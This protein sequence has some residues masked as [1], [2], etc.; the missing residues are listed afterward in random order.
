MLAYSGVAHS[1]YMLI[2]ISLLPT[3]TGRN[4]PEVIQG[5]EAVLFYLVAYGA[6][7]IGAFAVIA[8]L[9]TAERSIDNIED[10]AGLHESHPGI[11]L[12]M[13]IFLFS[14]IGL[15]A[16]A[17]FLA[18]FRLF[19]GALG[20]PITSSQ[21]LYQTLAIV[22]A[23]NA[24]I[25]A[26]YYLRVLSVMYLRGSFNAPKPVISYSIL[27]AILFCAAVTIVFGVFPSPLWNA[28]REAFH[29]V[30]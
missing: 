17:G 15:P 14:M 16:T 6:M 3:Q 8:Y 13:A 11:A 23:I 10:L 20:T 1:G 22:A 5:G 18:K 7:T 27:A 24:A 28:T 9:S 30:G 29:F 19:M 25:G 12:M 21:H 4:F 2:G 26:F